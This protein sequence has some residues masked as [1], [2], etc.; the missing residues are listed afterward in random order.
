MKPYLAEIQF[1]DELRKENIEVSA[2]NEKIAEA[3]AN[4][5]IEDV[6]MEK[7]SSI[8]IYKAEFLKELNL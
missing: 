8:K 1:K 7:I 6:G 4:F 2:N 5:I 3:L